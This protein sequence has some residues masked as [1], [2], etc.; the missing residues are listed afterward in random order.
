VGLSIPIIA[1]ISMLVGQDE[2]A[3]KETQ[4][5]KNIMKPVLVVLR[6]NQWFE[7]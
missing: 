1:S 7:H 6:Y 5:K 4:T 2:I 3:R